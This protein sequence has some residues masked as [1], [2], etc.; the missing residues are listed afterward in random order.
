MSDTIRSRSYLVG[1]FADNTMG[2]ITPQ[3]LRDFLFSMQL[4]TE[5]MAAYLQ[6]G[7]GNAMG[8]NLPMGGFKVTG[9]GNPS[10]SSDAAT[11]NYVDAFVQGLQIK[12]TA[13]AATI[14]T[15]PTNTYA[16]GTAGVGA[17]LTGNSNAALAAIDTYTPVLN[18]LI[19]VANE[20]TASR[21][22][23]YVLTQVGSGSLPYILTRHVDM[24]ETGDFSGSFIPVSGGAANANSIWIGNPTTPI[25]VGT[26]SIPFTRLNKAT[27]LAAGTNIQITGNTVATIATP[28]FVG[29]TLTGDL[30][31]SSHN[32]SGVSTLSN[33][34]GDLTI[35]PGYLYNLNLGIA[36]TTL[37]INLNGPTN[38]KG[39]ALNLNTGANTGGGT[40]N[41]DGGNITHGGTITATTHVGALTGHASLDLPLTGGTLSGNLLLGGH[42]ISGVATITNGGGDLSIDAGYLSTINLG[43]LFSSSLI[44]ANAQMNLVGNPLNMG[45]G[46]N[47]GGGDIN[48]AG[49][50]I[51]HGLTITAGTFVG[52]LTGHASLDLP[53]SGGTLSGNLAMGGH[54]ITGGGAITGTAIV[55]TTGVFSS[56]M[57]V[58]TQLQV[59][60]ATNSA[61][62]L[63]TNSGSK[64]IFFLSD[65]G[66]SQNYLLWDNGGS[67]QIGMATFAGGGYVNLGSISSAGLLTMVGGATFG[68]SVQ[69]GGHNISG[70]PTITNGSG[71]LTL[72]AGYLATLNLGILY[73]SSLIN[74]NAQMNFGGNPLN[75]GTGSGTG[76][77]T[78][79]MDGGN[80]SH[81][82]QISNTVQAL[83]DGSSI[84][85][86]L[87]LG[88]IATVTLGGNRTLAN[89][90][91]ILAGTTYCLKVTQDGTGSRTLAYGAA[92]KW[93]GG[94]APVLSTAIGAIDILTFIS[95]DGTTLDG[96]AQKA[97]A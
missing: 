47:T 3:M 1:V 48:L 12:P 15:L 93:P 6:V 20:A 13:N 66:G 63:G 26:T 10:A 18:S 81:C 54:A 59:N 45:T 73:S 61:T 39:N 17:T 85:W 4:T 8:A 41:L 62:F 56:T 82:G 60:S 68:A 96:V 76:G 90:T 43:I 80:I 37:A 94:V 83:T 2:L 53:L 31:L 5:A 50:S 65:G 28:S 44:N 25:T 11:K 92:F 64:H 19:L 89:P 36:T 72:D 7:G 70:V 78:L 34:N 38:L 57:L 67:L 52:S 40:L 86:N 35:D 49:G 71:D 23:L 14:T 97:F 30:V 32:I 74:A 77:G 27:D 46:G 16:N 9:L 51:T 88:V 87:T 22:G 42:N 75:M 58:D 55:G 21:N 84:A 91:N 95:F 69:M 29:A 79:S 24:D 33:G